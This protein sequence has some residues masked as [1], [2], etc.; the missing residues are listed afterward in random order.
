MDDIQ[1]ELRDGPRVNY[2]ALAG[3]VGGR[4]ASTPANHHAHIQDLRNRI[5]T[6][7]AEKRDV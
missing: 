3:A 5:A 7:E 1:R 2:A 4:P 6:I